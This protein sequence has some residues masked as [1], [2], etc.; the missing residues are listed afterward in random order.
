VNATRAETAP[1]PFLI[2]HRGGNRLERLR[3][4][5][6]LG[7][8]L[9]EADVRLFRGRLEVRHLKTVGPLPLLWDRWE[10]ASPWAPRLRLGPLLQATDPSTELLLDLKGPRRRVGELVANA[11]TPYLGRRRFTVC[12]RS[13]RVLEP[14]VGLPVR[15]FH[16]VGS[17]RQLARLL[18][19]LASSR[20][21]G[22]SIHARL[23]DRDV[24]REL[25]RV[26][27]VIVTWP[28]NRAE[29]ARR[30]TGLGVDGLISDEP[31]ALLGAADA[32]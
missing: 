8:S 21:D 15:R 3:E 28:V 27:D 31:A 18:R 19:G 30:L 12:A 16:S 7:I 29:D 25:R 6:R 4:S 2:A 22:V 24:V 17:K 13:P 11:L 20:A 9:V 5:E 23:L 10:L 32:L 14:F 1:R 26:A